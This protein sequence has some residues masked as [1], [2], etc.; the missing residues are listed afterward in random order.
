[1]SELF[2]DWRFALQ[3]L[4]AGWLL[5]L[6][7][8]AGV[9]AATT[10]LAAAPIYTTSISNLG[11]QS[12][13]ERSVDE[14]RNRVI[15]ATAFDLI[16]GDPVDR[17]KRDALVSITKTRLGHLADE[18]HI[19]ARTTRFDMN[20]VGYEGEVP[21]D[22]IEPDPGKLVRQ[23]WGSFIVWS[24]NF[25]RHVE[26]VDGRLP[27]VANATGDTFEAVL[28]DGFQKH[29]A[30]GDVV[31][32]ESSTFDD[33]PAI[34]IS[35]DPNVARDEI[36]CQPTI[37]ASTTVTAEIVGFVAPK[38]HR[39]LRWTFLQLNDNSGDWTPAAKPLI[40]RISTSDLSGADDVVT[41]RALTGEGS[42][43]LLTTSSQFFDVLG[44]QAPEIRT[45]YRLGI[46]P[47][48]SAISLPEVTRTLDELDAWSLDVGERLD[49]VASRQL[50]LKA[51]LEEFRNIQTFSQI[52]LLLILLQVVGVVLFYVI[53]VMAVLRER[54]SE[55]IAVYISRGAS[56]IQ[57]V[58]LALVEGLVITVP[59]VILAPFIAQF[60]VRILGFSSGFTPITNGTALPASLSSEAF[61]IAAV[62]GMLALFMMLLP[63][64]AGAREG[65]LDIQR[66]QARP[67]RRNFL[68]RYYL[69]FGMVFIALLLLWQLNQRGAVFDSD[70]V[71]GW[72]TDPLLLFSPLIFTLSVAGMFL[73][74]YPLL[75]SG[76]VRLLSVFQSTSISLGLLRASR[77]PTAYA[78][79]MLLVIMAVSVGT[80]AASYGPT[81]DRS[82]VERT[83]YEHG[84]SFRA[85]ILKST[86]KATFNDLEEVRSI[87][88]VRDAALVHR[89]VVDSISG[90]SVPLLA[91]DVPFTRDGFWFRE[92]LAVETDLPS[93]LAH[94]DSMIIPGEGITLPEDATQI[95]LFVSASDDFAG[96][97]HVSI[98]AIVVDAIGSYSGMLLEPSEGV[99]WVKS[100]GDLPF[101]IVPPVRL[102]SLELTDHPTTP[103]RVGD[104]L[105]FDEI[106]A[107]S[108]NGSRSLLENF[109]DEFRWKIFAPSGSDETFEPNS[110]RFIS[111]GNSGRWTRG[112]SDSTNRR[113]LALDD[114]VIPIAAVTNEMAARAFVTNPEGIGFAKLDGVL[115]PI[116]VNARVESFPTM[117][118]ETGIVVVNYEHLHSLAGAL[119]VPELQA[120]GEI[121]LDFE[122]G[123]SIDQQRAIVDS[124][125]NAD[126]AIGVS[127]RSGMLLSHE[128]EKIETDP[129]IQ[130]SGSGILTVA[131]I[132]VFSLALM[133]FI[134]TLVVVAQ[135]RLVE[136]TVLRA[137][138]TSPWQMLR[139][140]LL[141]WIAVFLIAG[142]IGIFLGR[143]I[144]RVMLS[145]L[146]VTEEGEQV[147]PPFILETDWRALAVAI[148]TLGV[149][150]L[151]GIILTWMAM[152]R[153]A[154]ASRL[155]ITR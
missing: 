28:P 3:R 106:T 79:L 22:P 88:G 147:L 139:A 27:L 148:G 81:V 105:F 131:F 30:I 150:V 128:L 56:T 116:R 127:A 54:Q 18:I 8:A 5:M 23:P 98:R 31:S 35:D 91:I 72:S 4:R 124:L 67:N 29:A 25:E 73:R 55:E 75:L 62:G 97:S 102:V 71:G 103:F 80:F 125:T 6:V 9:L 13:L 143:F 39:D 44:A 132:A 53:L 149:L 1:M 57:V 36:P 26:V 89:G 117:S 86:G 134:V 153:G 11:L 82:F 95:E 155:R 10:L 114:P 50:G 104:E 113:V 118:P 83:Q 20:F 7:A 119:D 33:C 85:T 129:T 32:L 24:S 70:A 108:S 59:S 58:G 136:A 14:P 46:V 41:A 90:V 21:E 96:K 17:A 76:V 42:F 146:E 140:M 69:D 152:M 12:G 60:V 100:V 93:L 111:G 34:E 47:D 65:I 19:E 43:P 74:F 16:I 123:T 48:L 115:A 130:A 92:D 133:S 126:A 63:S 77:E 2:A 101:G 37:I 109:D 49:L 68:Q 154:N 45:R 110:V 145:F 61:L 135:R 138:G 112:P 144:A 66:S 84:V 142:V 122:S 151:V 99:R 94:V 121:W 78:R 52:P 40:P 38:D 137:L 141:E 107:I 120:R 51:P 15:S 87:T 64:L